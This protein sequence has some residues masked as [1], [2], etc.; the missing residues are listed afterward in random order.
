[1]EA[2]IPVNI[3]RFVRMTIPYWLHIPLMWFWCWE[4][5]MQW[6]YGWKLYGK[7]LLRQVAGGAISIGNYFSAHSVSKGNSIGVNQPVILTAWGKGSSIT[8]GKNV[9]MSGCSITALERIVIGDRVL[10]GAGVL[11]MDNDAH[12]L[13]R[14]ERERG[15]T[16]A[17]APVHI[18]DDVFIGAR[19]IILKGVNIG[20]DA[21]VGAGSVVTKNVPVNAIV[22]GN[23][24]RVIGRIAAGSE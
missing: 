18:G 4:Q 11:I 21:V 24:A 13:T 5:G 22:A 16:P 2:K 12:P 1:M 23:P 19:A 10:I 14:E 7:P 8:I 6:R 3:K 9:G 20:S 15:D 17:T